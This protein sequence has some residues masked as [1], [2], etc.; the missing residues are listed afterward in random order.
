MNALMQA[1]VWKEAKSWLGSR[2]ERSWIQ[3]ED[4]FYVCKREF[5]SLAGRSLACSCDSA[6]VPHQ[7]SHQWSAWSRIQE[8]GIAIQN[9]GP[10][11]AARMVGE[12][13]A[14]R[15]KARPGLD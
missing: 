11:Y 6:G 13:C 10:Q 5:L 3:G 2:I 12:R 8:E 14:G 15:S 7:G 1:I 4:R 9:G